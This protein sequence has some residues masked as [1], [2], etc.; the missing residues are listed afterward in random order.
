MLSHFAELIGGLNVKYKTT[1][2]PGFNIICPITPEEQISDEDQSIYCAGVGTLLYLIK[3]S[4]PDLSNV[5][6]ELFK[7][8]DKATPA[9]FKELK[10]VMHFVA[11][12]KAY[13]LKV[14]PTKA[15]PDMFHWKM[16]VYTD[17]DW[18]GD[19]EGHHSISGNVIYLLGV[20]V[21]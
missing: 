9:A 6:Q 1:G 10:H 14:E 18:A 8:M 12:T 15:D 19:K 11:A 20:P 17:S 3:H 21:L 13:G 16:V 2:M 7:C 5:V 4:C